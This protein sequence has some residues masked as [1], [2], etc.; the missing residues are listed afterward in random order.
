MNKVFLI[1]A[2]LLAACGPADL[3]TNE[4]D[5]VAIVDPHAETIGFIETNEC[6]WNLGDSACDFQLL[7][8]EEES[9]RLSDYLGD[10]VLIDLSAMWCGPCNSAAMSTQSIQSQYESQGFQYVTILIVDSQNDTVEHEDVEKWS[11]LYGLA[12]APVLRGDRNLVQ[13]A[14]MTYGF[15]VQ[16]WPTFILVNRSGEVVYGLR[17]YNQ[18]WLIEEIEANL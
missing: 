6:G 3:K 16:S 5:S 15:P 17:G 14:T 11:N 7:D 13:S 10:V 9:W 8:Q 2:T 4:E 18:E 1:L 12:T